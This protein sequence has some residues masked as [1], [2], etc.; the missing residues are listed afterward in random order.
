LFAPGADY[1]AIVCDMRMPGLSG[2]ELHDRLVQQAP[3]W[4]GRMLFVT[5]D[6]ASNESVEF[7]ARSQAPIV[8]KPVTA[9]ELLR[10]VRA[11]AD[12]G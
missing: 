10:R 3:Q 7:A 6:L 9:R 1:A 12:S 8:T 4:L 5:G 2:P 11:L